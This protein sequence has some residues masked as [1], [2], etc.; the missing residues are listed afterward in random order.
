MSLVRVRK[1]VWARGDGMSEYAS[2]SVGDYVVRPAHGGG[3]EW[4]LCIKGRTVHADT[5]EA[6]K[7]ACQADFE[8]RVLSE[9]E[10]VPL[11]FPDGHGWSECRN[12]YVKNSAR[13][14]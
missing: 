3:W 2:S 11:S 6:A 1:L 10:V 4:W 14:R 5:I 8:R 12:Y 13:S 9:I 7:A